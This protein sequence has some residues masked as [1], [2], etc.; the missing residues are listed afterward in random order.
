MNSPRVARGFMILACAA[1][2]VWSASFAEGEDA[3]NSASAVI[4]AADIDSAALDSILTG[5][6]DIDY[7][8]EFDFTY[9]TL[10]VDSSAVRMF[11]LHP[12]LD[13]V[14]KYSPR[15][16]LNDDETLYPVMPH[17]FAFDGEDNNGDGLFDLEDPL[18]LGA[19]LLNLEAISRFHIAKR[20]MLVIIDNKALLDEIRWPYRNQSQRWLVGAA[21]REALRS[22]GIELSPKAF[23][24]VERSQ[25]ELVDPLS[26]AKL[27]DELSRSI[28]ELRGDSSSLDDKAL[29]RLR[30]FGIPLD[31]ARVTPFISPEDQEEGRILAGRSTWGPSIQFTAFR[32]DSV[33][34]LYQGIGRGGDVSAARND[35]DQPSRRGATIYGVYGLDAPPD[36]PLS[37]RDRIILTRS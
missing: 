27:D 37:Y 13:Q 9:D 21:T 10:F 1:L 20:P 23:F 16:V 24:S 36:F 34:S 4:G 26:W 31:Q 33:L 15:I 28:W 25:G 30:H 14:T 8:T 18:E 11:A 12:Q 29:S 5:F 6:K 32:E 17:A 35:G 19:G 2:A 7:P 22:A 3:R